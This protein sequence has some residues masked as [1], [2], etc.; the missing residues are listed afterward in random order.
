MEIKA[1]HLYK[2]YNKLTILNDVSFVLEK[3]QK[4]GLVGSNGIG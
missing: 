4:A 3:G 2:S 1:E